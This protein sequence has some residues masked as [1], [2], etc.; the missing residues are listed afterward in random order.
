MNSF[1]SSVTSVNDAV[2][3]FV[4]GKVGLILLIGTGILLTVVTKVFQISHLRHW[5]KSTIG[6]LFHRDVIGHSK[7]ARS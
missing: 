6:S 5:W 1:F 2:N 4:W 7:D 3:S